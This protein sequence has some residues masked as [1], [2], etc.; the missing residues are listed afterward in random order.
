MRNWAM[1]EKQ[2]VING[3]F[4]DV[5]HHRLY[6]GTN[7]VST[8]LIESAD[9]P[10]FANGVG[11][12]EKNISTGAIVTLT[13]AESSMRGKNGT[14]PKGDS[15]VITAIGIHIAL[16]NIQATT[17]F[18]DDSVT[19]IDVTP[20]TRVSPY[21]LLE[22]LKSQCTFELYRNSDELLERGN[23]DEYPAQFG[24]QGFAGGSGAAVPALAG[25]AQ[26]AYTVNPSQWIQTNGMMF[27]S[28]TV[29]QVLEELDQFYGIFK[30]NR[31]ID[32][33]DTL[34]VGHIDFYLVGRA[35]TKYEARQ[36]V[37]N[38]AA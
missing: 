20:I 6:F 36:Y 13:D 5:I 18:E 30:V 17:P 1:N 9:F 31:P 14:I 35:T 12:Q 38:F 3:A 24:A 7:G 21:P 16:S 28:L 8:S 19:S 10:V 26:D 32:L 11:Q 22:A 33:A 27:R 25:G 34:L 29:F 23:I 2:L 37:A 15:F 4:N